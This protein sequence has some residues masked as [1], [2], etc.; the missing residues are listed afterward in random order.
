MENF[1]KNIPVDSELAQI[2]NEIAAIEALLPLERNDVELV[3]KLRILKQKA[4]QIKA[5]TAN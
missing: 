5:D 1:E 4:V 3:E 2:E